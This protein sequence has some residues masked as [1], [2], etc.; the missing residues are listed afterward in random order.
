MCQTGPS[1]IHSVLDKV[2]PGYYHRRTESG[3][4]CNSTCCNNTA[5]EHAMCERLVIDDIVHWAKQYKVG[6]FQLCFCST[7]EA[8]NIRAATPFPQEIRWRIEAAS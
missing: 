2:V 7:E 1:S 3:E 6:R 4:I 5:T 8:L